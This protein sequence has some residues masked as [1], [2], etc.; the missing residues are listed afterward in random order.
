MRVVSCRLFRCICF[1]S[2]NS[3]LSPTF[4]GFLT[5][6]A[7][8]LLGWRLNQSSK[9][10]RLEFPSENFHLL[11]LSLAEFRR[12][13]IW[14]ARCARNWSHRL[15]VFGDPVAS[16]IGL[17]RKPSGSNCW[18]CS[19]KETA[20]GFSD[21]ADRATTPRVAERGIEEQFVEILEGIVECLVNWVWIRN[22]A[23]KFFHKFSKFWILCRFYVSFQTEI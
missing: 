1:G 3:R 7:I 20:K 21:P 18:R 4:N 16:Q 6:F 22:G 15:W 23:K 19:G 5:T 2:E 13:A 14:A 12:R 10:A 11:T 9:L 17:I 8:R